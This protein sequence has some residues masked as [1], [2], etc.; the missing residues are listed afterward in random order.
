MKKA[1]LVLAAFLF[2]TGCFVS[3]QSLF[4]GEACAAEKTKLDIGSARDIYDGSLFPDKAV[5]TYSN[6]D[7]IFPTRTIKAGGK[8][9]PL[10]VSDTPLK[11]L[12]FSS[13]GK[14]YDLPDYVALNRMVGL[15]I[16]KDGKI[17]FEHYDFGFTPRTRW[18]SMSL[19]KSFVSTLVG[20][21]VKDKFITSINDPVT[22]YI[23]QL[24]GSAYE[25]VSV[26]DVLMMSSGVKWDET[27]VDPASDRRKLLE[28]QIASNKPGAIFDLMKSLPKA[29]KPGIK[30]NYN[31]GE[32]V[33]IGEIVQ[34]ATKKH[35]ADYLS[36]KIWKPLGME[37]NASWWLDSPN[38]HEVGGSGVLATLRDFGRF[39]QF[40]LNGAQIDG[41]KIVPDWWLADATSAKPIEGVGSP[42]GYAYQWWTVKA[43]AG[44][45]HDGVFMGRGIHGQYLYINPKNNVVV[46]GLGAR[47]K[48]VGKNAI[49]DLDFLAAVV[50]KLGNK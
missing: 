49:D 38:G 23:P 32:T 45:V 19:A 43:E 1:A 26:R 14:T 40:I 13:A 2:L 10:P 46:V 11:T 31:T 30:F 20:A 7:K 6:T 17:V 5:R 37:T 28:L 4:I 9:Y 27:Y 15:L 36:Q 42:N 34:A 24:K 29:A 48:P 47:P 25:D 3:Q 50:K 33:L 35:L 12:S 39:G 22:K 8:P 16:L 21:A 18:M 41:K 44:S